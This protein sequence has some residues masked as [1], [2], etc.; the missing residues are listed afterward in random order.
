MGM[1]VKIN[2]L[3]LFLLVRDA[4]GRPFEI[5]YIKK[6]LDDTFRK[7]LGYVT[8]FGSFVTKEPSPEEIH[9]FER[10]RR[11]HPVNGRFI[12]SWS[13]KDIVNPTNEKA[14]FPAFKLALEHIKDYNHCK[15]KCEP[16]ESVKK[17]IEE[18]IQGKEQ[19]L[20]QATKDEN[21]SVTLGTF[22]TKDSDKCIEFIGKELAPHN[23]PQGKLIAL[24]LIGFANAGYLNS[25][26]GSLLK[27]R[28]ALEGQFPGLISSHQAIS[29]YTNPYYNKESMS[30][31]S[32]QSK[33]ISEMTKKIQ[34][35]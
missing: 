5:E 29:K 1:E 11:H 31:V 18:W 17:V 9:L 19:E 16:K 14:V 23:K 10:K 32:L 22:F 30:E 3:D 35:I 4:N 25:L 27:I 26:Q 7:Q 8:T 34:N 28:G 24:I 15:L 12:R 13:R 21:Q 20:R 2:G 33:E 6:R